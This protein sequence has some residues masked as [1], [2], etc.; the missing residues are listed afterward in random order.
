MYATLNISNRS[1]KVLSIS[2]RRVKKWGSLNLA[3]GLVQDGFIIEPRAFGEAIASLFKSTKIPKERVIVSLGGLVFTYRFINLP[4][5]K[6]TLVDEAIRRA[7]KKEISLPLDELYLSWQALPGRNEELIYFVAGVP[8][9]FVDSLAETLKIAGIAPF[10]MD[11]QPLALARA[12]NCQD[13]IVVNMEPE[14]YDIVIIADGVPAV[15]HT[16]SPRGGGATLEDNIKRLADELTKTVAFYQSRHPEN[17]LTPEATLLLTGELTSGA[18]VAGLLQSEIKYTVKSLSPA[19]DSPPE[20]PLPSYTTNIGLAMK[21]LRPEAIDGGG[22]GRFH[23]INI[24]IFSDKYHQIRKKPIPA[25]YILFWAFLTLIIALLFPL[26]LSL[27]RVN[28]E[29]ER[30][31]SQFSNINR[32]LN[33]ATIASEANAR[34]ENTIQE[35][36]AQTT[37]LQAA[38]QTILADRGIFTRDLQLIT[39]TLPPLTYL[40]SA[41]ID[42]NTI[43]LRGETENVFSAVDYAAALESIGAF[44]DVRITELNEVTR[45]IPGDN[46]TSEPAI[47]RVLTFEI[48]LNQPTQAK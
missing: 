20:L 44:T 43:T 7:A 17:A 25:R 10:L 36:I 16:I 31:Q 39:G 40:T 48:T 4:R 11:L 34:T 37:A 27:N 6:P 15:I 28:A 41:E 29:N 45:I 12:A 23:D 32:E 24:N 9:R 2:G 8:R 14:S 1:L 5:M 30:L 42:H 22:D 47:L 38:D 35:I 26:H 21:K 13:A 19:L 3:N 33:F 46:T 18:P